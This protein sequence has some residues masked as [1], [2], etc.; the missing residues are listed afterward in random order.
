MMPSAHRLA[1]SRLGRNVVLG[2]VGCAGAGAIALGLPEKSTAFRISM[3]SAYVALLYLALTLSLGPL[4]AVLYRREPV[5]TYVRRDI[6]IWSAMFALVHVVAALQV[7]FAGR[8]SAYFLSAE[9]PLPRF[10]LFGLANY[11]GLGLTGGVVVLLAIS[12]DASMREMGIA[13][14][15]RVQRIA[16]WIGLL[17]M[18][19]AGLYQAIE[20]RSLGFIAATLL[21]GIAVLWC[22]WLRSRQLR[23]TEG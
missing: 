2:V 21:I 9:G 5:S 1:A 15:R 20:R 18:I 8:I 17:T 3:G 11:I 19:H 12:N 4:Y 7:H 16:P 14:W 13:R 23:T 10:D 22:R 6:A